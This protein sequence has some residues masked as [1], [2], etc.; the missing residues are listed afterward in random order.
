MKTKPS[1]QEI[2]AY[3]TEHSKDENAKNV[4][5]LYIQK[6]EN[7]HY[8]TGFS[9]SF[10]RI[11]LSPTKAFLISDSRYSESAQRFAQ[12]FGFEYREIISGEKGKNFWKDLEKE[13]EISYL[14]FESHNCTYQQ[15]ENLQKIFTSK[16]IPVPD[17]IE[18]FRTKKS[19]LELSCIQ[20]AAQI[21]DAALQKTVESFA[22]GVTEKELALIF[23]FEAR[24][25]LGAES[26]S[27]DTIVGF[28]RNSAIPHHFSSDEK[29]TPNT[30][31][32][33]DCGVKFSGYCSDMTRCFWFGRPETD[34]EKARFQEWKTAYELV[35]KAQKEGIQEMNVLGEI[36]A[37]DKKAREV[38][39]EQ[40]EFFTH[41]FGHGVGLEIH[42]Y[43]GVSERVPAEKKF[44]ENMIVTAEPGLYFSGKFGIRI[45]DLLIITKNGAEKLS[46]F[47]YAF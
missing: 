45:E 8:L 31:I 29:L 27:F 47:P 22:E 43:P 28:G 25:F 26:L 44:Q 3:I 21:G 6:P 12:M 4:N 32:L 7:I 20:K 24:K 36:S 18:H 40:S 17:T 1:A 34:D 33:I 16:T 5:G 46:Q 41:T 14:G 15:F 19:E 35:Y 37:P 13:A 23:E 38:F 39:G 9:G 11:L 2:F 10:G 30:P 42:E